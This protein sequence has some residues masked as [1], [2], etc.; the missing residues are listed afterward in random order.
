[1][2]TDYIT[3]TNFYFGKSFNFANPEIFSIST[4][5]TWIVNVSG[6]FKGD[7]DMTNCYHL[8]NMTFPHNVYHK[9]C[10]N[11]TGCNTSTYS[12]QSTVPHKWIEK[13]KDIFCNN[14][15]NSKMTELC[16]VIIHGV[17]DWLSRAVI[18]VP[19]DLIIYNT[20]FVCS[21]EVHERTEMIEFS[22]FLV[23]TSHDSFFHSSSFRQHILN[24]QNIFFMCKD[25]TFIL[26]YHECDGIGNCP[27]CEDEQ[28]CTNVCD[29]HQNAIPINRNCFT[30]CHMSNCTCSAL[31]Y[32]CKLGGC[33]RSSKI[34]DDHDDCIDGSDELME[35]CSGHYHLFHSMF[36]H[37][38]KETLMI[39]SVHSVLSCSNF[40]IPSFQFCDGV[41]HCDHGLDERKAICDSVTIPLSLQCPGEGIFVTP[42]WVT[43]EIVHCK[44][45][46]DDELP[47]LMDEHLPPS[48]QGKG[49]AV[50]CSETSSV[51]ALKNMT[52]SLTLNRI[53]FHNNEPYTLNHVP[54]LIIL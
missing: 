46:F 37:N 30:S 24:K 8:N 54:L 22:D 23:K 21:Y 38:W 12:N 6:I 35:I 36:N 3:N 33:I 10:K 50:M 31:F 11:K 53:M 27:E 5:A 16:T 41:S 14:V 43:D 13:N 51:P 48:C 25:R 19:C 47:S 45:S 15:T 17:L 18:L 52:K 9:K 2:D 32:Q 29:F 40:L 26:N 20:K 4:T 39:P 28:N 49:F 42:Q 34:C 7:F 44:F 1:M